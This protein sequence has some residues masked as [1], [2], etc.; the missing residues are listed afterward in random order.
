MG[1]KTLQKAVALLLLLKNRLGK[2]SV[3]NNASQNQIARVAGVSPSTISRYLPLWQE[4]G[5]VVW[6]G[7]RSDM[8]VVKRLS[9]KTDHRNYDV[10]RLDYS[11][12]KSLY[13]S[14]RDFLFLIVQSRKDYIKRMIRIATNPNWNENFKAARKTCKRYA[15]MYRGD[16]TETYH[17]FGLSYK[18]IAQKLGFCAKTAQNI[19]S[20][21]I[22]RRWCRKF[23]HYSWT[24]LRGVMGMFVNGFTFT[25]RNYGF[26]VEANTYEMSHYWHLVLI[27]GKK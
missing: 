27:D 22:K 18:C 9:S 11:S 26:V 16:E 12:F 7:K 8:L 17:E 3:I 21:T 25:T 4:L 6:Q 23:T 13:H 15:K 19:V 10:Q 20:D 5:F 1:D 14:F 24:I 2:T